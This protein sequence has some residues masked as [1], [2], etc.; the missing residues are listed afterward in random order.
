M[1][2]DVIL[3]VVCKPIVK[4]CEKSG[5][6]DKPVTLEEVVMN[7]MIRFQ[8]SSKLFIILVCFILMAAF[9][10]TSCIAINPAPTPT[11]AD[12]WETPEPPL[13]ESPPP[14]P[15][16]VTGSAILP[17]YTGPGVKITSSELF[18]SGS[19]PCKQWS[20]LPVIDIVVRSHIQSYFSED[21][22]GCISFEIGPESGGWG[23][24]STEVILNNAMT[25]TDEGELFTTH[26]RV[27]FHLHSETN[28]WC[29]IW[30]MSY[31]P[32]K[33]NEVSWEIYVWE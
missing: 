11:P 30:F 25:T 18:C 24:N 2:P 20:D 1:D 12:W 5:F 6:L 19:L 29:R 22:P 10:P 15:P 13:P 17:C 7:R 4:F 23:A 9:L 26:V 14:W 32:S 33:E 8:N 16:K 31:D 21:R 27:R 3:F 28:P